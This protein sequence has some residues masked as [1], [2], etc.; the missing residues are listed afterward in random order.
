MPAELDPA[1]YGLTIWDLDREFLTGGVGGMP[2]MTLGDLL[3][4]L[5]DA[6][7]RTHRHRVHAHPGD[8]R[9]ALDPGAGRGR[10]VARS[11]KDAASTTSSTGSTR[12]R[13]SRSSSPPS[14]SAR[15][16]SASKGAESAIPIL[17]QLLSTAADAGLDSLG[18]R[19]GPPRPAQRAR[20]HHRQELRPDLQGVRGPRRP[21]VRAGLGRREVPPRGHRQVREPVRAPTSASSWPP[22]R[23]TSRPSTRSCSAWSAPSRT[24]ID[25]PGSFPVLPILIHGDAAFAGQGVVAECLGDERHQ[26]LPRRR[27]DPPDHQQPDRLHHQ[28]AEL[29]AARVYCTDVAKMVQAP[30]FHVNGDDPEA[31]VRVGR[32]GLRVPPDVPQGRRHRHGLLPPPRPQRGRRPE[33][34]PAADV[35]GDR[36]AAQRAQALH[37]GARQARR[38]HRRGGR[39]RARRLPGASC[40]R[41][42]TRPAQHAPDAVK[43][44]KPPKPHGR[45]AAR[46][47]RRRPRPCSTGSST[48]SPPIPEGF[49]AAPEAG[50][51]VRAPRQAVPRARAWS[52]G[53]PARR[54]PSARW[55]SR[56]TPC[57][58]PARTPAAARSASATPRSST[59]TTRTPWIPLTDARR[60]AGARSGST[61]RCCREYAA[62]GFEYGY[63]LANKDALVVWEAQFG[64]FINGAQIII[65]Q[66]LVAAEDKWGQ[67]TGLVLLLPARLRGPG[68]RALLGPHRAVPHAVRR[69]QHPGRATPPP[70]RSTSTSCAAR[71]AATCASRSSCSRRSRRCA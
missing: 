13:R 42:S 48:T 29:R 27:H 68:P 70:R 23:A 36:R 2:K 50:P 40:S 15:S 22:T 20:Q 71:C 4:V 51:P 47:D 6:Y 34:H 53:P 60:R 18:H 31:C 24:S 30:I 45:A 14:T 61:T 67:T 57:A 64:D 54:W 21:D 55:C 66:Y 43:V 1:T 5:R 41:R 59:T 3:G 38:P 46:R 16:A 32:A 25:P 37:R 28:P 63:S 26:R 17:D 35:Q 39:G 56:A 12:P 7:C 62:L 33:L 58:S 19:H 49:T 65:D 69:G 8:R 9:A 10:V 44:A 52:T 11:T